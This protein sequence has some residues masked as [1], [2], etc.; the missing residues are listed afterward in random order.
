[1]PRH[2]QRP[3]IGLLIKWVI[4]LQ[5]ESLEHRAVVAQVLFGI[6]KVLGK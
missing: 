1:V 2:H 3:L 5:M 4:H 6:A